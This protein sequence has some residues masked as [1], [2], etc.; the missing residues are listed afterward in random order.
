MK[1]DAFSIG[2]EF[3]T[4]PVMITKEDIIAFGEK[5]DPQYFHIDEQAAA[6]S[7]F[8]S[9]IASGF[10]T[11]AVV[12]SEWIKM[13]ILSEDCLGGV[14]ADEIRWKKPVRAND[15]LAGRFTVAAK[16]IDS[17]GKR[18]LLTLK[19]IIKNQRDE[20]V[21]TCSTNVYVQA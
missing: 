21:L 14:G 15:W 13:D 7:L 6:N 12:W 10:H 4:E 2:Q 19:I 11:L 8:G 20:E 18:G 3:H 16:K 5:Y 9:L 17:N 1:F